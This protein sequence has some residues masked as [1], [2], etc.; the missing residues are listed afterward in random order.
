MT[1]LGDLAVFLTLRHLNLFF[2]TIRYD[3]P[4]TEYLSEGLVGD[5]YLFVCLFTRVKK[6]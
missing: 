3:D 6:D 2:Y 1:V 4:N 5:V